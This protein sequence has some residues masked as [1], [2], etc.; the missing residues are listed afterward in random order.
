VTRTH[1]IEDFPAGASMVIAE[2]I[3]VIRDHVPAVDPVLDQLKAADF[4]NP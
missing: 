4:T 1:P 3:D 2:L